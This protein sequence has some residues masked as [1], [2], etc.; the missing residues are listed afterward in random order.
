MNAIHCN[1]RPLL[2][3]DAMPTRSISGQDPCEE[4]TARTPQFC[5]PLAPAY[6]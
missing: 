2:A 4:V 1:L 3:I 6:Q 5:A